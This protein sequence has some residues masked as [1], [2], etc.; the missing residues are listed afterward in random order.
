MDNLF[1]IFL[2]FNLAS[3]TSANNYS[4]PLSSSDLKMRQN[5]SELVEKEKPFFETVNRNAPQGTPM[6]GE[7]SVVNIKARQPGFVLRGGDFINLGVPLGKT[8]PSL[9]RVCTLGWAVKRI[10]GGSFFS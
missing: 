7:S 2:I 3:S 8:S 1:K 9:P 6:G 10:K 4:L 5:V